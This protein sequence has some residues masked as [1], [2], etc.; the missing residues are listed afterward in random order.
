MYL[1]NVST[2]SSL[3]TLRLL[4]VIRVAGGQRLCFLDGPGGSGLVFYIKKLDFLFRLCV[5]IRPF[6]ALRIPP[7]AQA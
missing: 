1:H 5:I 2:V 4:Q 7:K 6:L 3:F